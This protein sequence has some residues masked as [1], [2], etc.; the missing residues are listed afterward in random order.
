MKK[1][2]RAIPLLAVGTGTPLT[3]S[4]LLRAWPRAAPAWVRGGFDHGSA[5]SGLSW[6]GE[7]G[8]SSMNGVP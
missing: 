4:L 2:F 7:V 3:M 5:R 1:A 8:T 6:F